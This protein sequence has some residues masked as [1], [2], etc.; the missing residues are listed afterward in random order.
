MATPKL[1][2]RCTDVSLSINYSSLADIEKEARETRLYLEGQGWSN[3]QVEMVG[4]AYSN[5]DREYPY[6]FGDRMETE[7]EAEKRE[8]QEAEIAARNAER[9]RAQYERLRRQFEGE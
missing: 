7:E 4:E 1:T 6:I 5:S 9:D 3:L 2:R 8:A